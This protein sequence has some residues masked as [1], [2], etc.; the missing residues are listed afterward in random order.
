[1]QSR[2][3][4]T[5]ASLSVA[6]YRGKN[7][8]YSIRNKELADAKSASLVLG[9]SETWRTAHF[10]PASVNGERAK[11]RVA[12]YSTRVYCLDGGNRVIEQW[13]LDG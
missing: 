8:P 1:M 12:H 3:D 5:A 6:S 13:R 11:T 9:Y 4:A 2:K 10:E 7:C